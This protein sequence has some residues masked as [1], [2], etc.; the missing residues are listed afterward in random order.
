MNY[1]KKADFYNKISKLRNQWGFDDNTY[2]IDFVTLCRQKGIEVGAVPFFTPGL[3][4]MASLSTGT[5]KDV[6]ILNTARNKFEQNVDCT[7][8]FIHINFHKSEGYQSFKCFEK[9]QPNQNEYLEWQANEG[10]AELNVPYMTL[11]PKIKKNYHLLNTYN[12]IIHFKEELVQEYH[13]TSAVIEYRLESLKYEI[14]Q[15]VNG[16]SIQNL[17][18]LS[19]NSQIKHGIK[20]KSLNDKAND[21]LNSN[22]K[23][24]CGIS[25]NEWVAYTIIQEWKNILLDLGGVI[26][27]TFCN[28]VLEFNGNNCFTILF[29]DYNSYLIGSRQS[30]ISELKSHILKKYGKDFHFNTC[31]ENS[32]CIQISNKNVRSHIISI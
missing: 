23:K 26:R 15:F 13:V 9:A 30:I 16:I 2:K 14:E 22:F 20:I 8:E 24:H 6:I 5:Q 31:L 4:G 32:S 19:Y 29:K 11:L 28:T 25:A 21:D 10:G 1:I 7:H 12:D 27:A 3:R 18:I 17:R